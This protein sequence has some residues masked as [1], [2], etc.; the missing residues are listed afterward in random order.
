MLDFAVNSMDPDGDDVRYHVDWGD[1]ENETTSFQESGIDVI[2]AHSWSESGIYYIVI[3]SEDIHGAIGDEFWGKFVV[4]NSKSINRPI[5]QLF[6][7]HS[8][9]F[10]FLHLLLDIWRLNIE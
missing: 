2:V 3:E 4:R 1:G 5:S 10:L 9:L 7:C 8:N 6:R